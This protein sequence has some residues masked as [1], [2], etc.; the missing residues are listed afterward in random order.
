MACNLVKGGH[1]VTGYDLNPQ[2]LDALAQAGGQRA[3]SAREAAA[4]PAWSS[5]CCRPR[6]ISRRRSKAPTAPCRAWT[7]ARS[8]STCPPSCPRK[9]T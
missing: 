1:A 2:A 5:P 7:R 8:S 4:G 9:P 3:A 6:R